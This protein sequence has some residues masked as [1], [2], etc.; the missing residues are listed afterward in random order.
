MISIAF[1]LLGCSQSTW[2][3][4]INVQQGNVI[5]NDVIH[6]LHVGM[7]KEAVSDLLGP[8]V[9][10][11]TF[12]DSRWT[13]IYTLKTGRGQHLEKNLV[14]YFCNDRITGMSSK[15]LD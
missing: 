3:Y 10:V 11:D 9:L 7:T 4:R 6:Q 14:I 15:N 1:A 13:Y 2:L 12:N 8:P 5:S